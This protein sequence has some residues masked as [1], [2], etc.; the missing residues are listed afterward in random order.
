VAG[1]SRGGRRA[2]RTVAARDARRP[3]A[4][5]RR[6][7]PAEDGLAAPLAEARDDLDRAEAFYRRD[8][9]AD[10]AEAYAALHRRCEDLRRRD[11][12]RRRAIVEREQANAAAER[13]PTAGSMDMAG[14]WHEAEY[15]FILAKK[16]FDEG[17]FDQ[18]GSMW[19]R[20]AVLYDEARIEAAARQAD[21][22]VRAL[23]GE[24]D[25]MGD[26]LDRLGAENARLLRR[27]E[28]FA[29]RLTGLEASVAQQ[30]HQ[31]ELLSGQLDERNAAVGQLTE[32]LRRAELRGQEL[33][34]DMEAA[35]Q[36]ATARQREL[37]V[38]VEKI[39]ELEARLAGTDGG[40][41]TAGLTGRVLN[42]VP[43][44]Q[45][46][47]L[48]VGET[49]GV[50]PGMRFTLSRGGE[51]VGEFEV[52]GVNSSTCEGRFDNPRQPP[53]IGDI[54]R[55]QGPPP[56]APAGRD[57]SGRVT[58][59]DAGHQVAQLN[60]GTADGV[61]EGMRF[62]L[63]RGTDFVGEL[64]VAEVDPH[65]CAGL[66]SKLQTTPQPRDQATT[67]PGAD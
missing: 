7:L 49:D 4:G 16:A 19:R 56:A 60:V 5:A 24:K 32:E 21:E 64:T 27:D 20:G 11:D 1:R 18:A 15:A 34:R 53:R 17:E 13:A 46:A 37:A 67:S 44:K 52:T 38:A 65:S 23:T 54:A 14:P 62:I 36:L 30:V 35:R 51:V 55:R 63:Y 28:A 29:E 22:R 25:R 43:E 57:I 8:A 10:A 61:V 48:N 39:H 58:A 26:E 42:V 47:F 45:I 59:V 40:G 41:E 6:D 12:S 50:K 3:G 31:N 2:G 9:F 33:A 66:L